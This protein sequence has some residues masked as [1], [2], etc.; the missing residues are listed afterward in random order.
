MVARVA[1]AAPEFVASA[2]AAQLADWLAYVEPDVVALTGREPAPRA[3]NALRR[4]CDPETLLFQP[5]A[6]GEGVRTPETVRGPRTVDDVQFVFAPE[7]EDLREVAGAE[8]A[9]LGSDG[10]SLDPERPTIL[11]S[12]ALELDVDTTSLATDLVGR[13]DYV[14]ALSPD[15]LDGTYVHVSTRLPAG[16]RQEWDGL[17]I[18][19]AGVDAGTGDSPLVTLDCRADG[20]VLRRELRPD[21]LGLRAL[22][23]VGEAR[24]R[25]LRRAGITDRG[26]LADAAVADIATVEGIG[27]ATAERVQ[28]SARALARG[29]IVRESDATLPGGEPLFVD[30]ETDGLNPTITWLVGV[31]DGD[32]YMPFIQRDPDEPG[33]AIEDFVA[34]YTANAARRP[35]VAYRGWG[36][37]FE[38]LHEHI[39]EYCPHY[40]DEWERSY[41]F[42]PYYWAVEQ[43]NA[44]LPGRTNKLEDVAR[45]LGYERAEADLTGAAVARTYRRWMTGGQEPEWERF[46]RYCEDDVR[47]LAVVYEA[48]QDSSRIVSTSRDQDGR[49]SR[50]GQNNGET[51]QGT[52]SDW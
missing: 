30:I 52:L 28:A 29:E 11:V 25:R 47:A 7:G 9:A 48:L 8:G 24:A 46:K 20:E 32:R 43:G 13:E 37:D 2:S 16:Y 36:F 27:R 50:D 42:D 26:Q 38:V 15:A 14:E 44:V 49:G 22:D 45:A 17:R 40:A 5:T 10:E 19:G 41:R 35:L 39:L 12:A 34:W 21:R 18:V 33:R 3:M 51:T 31:L 1:T 6:G 4:A 23:R